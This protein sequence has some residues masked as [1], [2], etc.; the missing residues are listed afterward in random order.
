[1][2]PVR[3]ST[4]TWAC[5]L[6]A[7]VISAMSAASFCRADTVSVIGTLTVQTTSYVDNFSIGTMAGSQLSVA[8]PLPA[9]SADFSALG[10]TEFSVTFQAPAGK[11][12]ELTVPTGF[13]TVRLGASYRGLTSSF[14]IGRFSTAAATV[15]VGGASGESLPT[16]Q[17]SVVLTGPGGDFKAVMAN[18]GSL[19]PGK[20]YRFESITVS[21][22]VPAAY[23]VV[24]D[25]AIVSTFQLF[26]TASFSGD[27]ADPG[28]LLR[29]VDAPAAVPTPAA[30]AGGLTLL[31]G[32][33]AFTRRR[34][35]L[36]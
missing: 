34:A 19:T 33:A 8:A 14:G 21:A 29:L 25:D 18:F 2:R 30:A 20:T 10:D 31:G 36:A 28:Q 15:S 16:T 6:A 32:L 23:D 11:A 7:A 17:G 5:A 24:F 3:F 22:T 12:I 9:F 27:A 26:T 1:M 35:P 4:R 13:D